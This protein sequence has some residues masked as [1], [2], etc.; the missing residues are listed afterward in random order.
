MKCGPTRPSALQR[1]HRVISC[2][3]AHAVLIVVRGD[4]HHARLRRQHEVRDA[5]CA[6]RRH[7]G[8]AHAAAKLEAVSMPSQIAS[9]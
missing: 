5:A 6:Q 3:L 4:N 7:V 9:H 1:F 2:A 8:R